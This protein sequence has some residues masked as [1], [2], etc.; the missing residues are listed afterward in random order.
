MMKVEF[1]SRLAQTVTAEEYELIELVYTYHP[2]VDD[3]DDIVELYNIGG[4]TLMKDMRARACNLRDNENNQLHLRREIEAAQKEAG[5]AVAK[6]KR[7]EAELEERIESH[8]LVT[9]G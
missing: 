1:E 2:A 9:K 5:D 7:L 6:V 3:K 4:L 8:R